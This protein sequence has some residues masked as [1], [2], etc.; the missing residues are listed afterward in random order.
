[1]RRDLSKGD[2]PALILAVL[3][4]GPCH[5]YAI[6]REIERQSGQLFQMREGKLYPLLRV[7]EQ[8]GFIEGQWDTRVSGA[9]R[10]VYALTATG[11]GELA[12]R[13]HAWKNYVDGVSSI[14]GGNKDAQPA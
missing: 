12:K 5:G 3:Q 10:K 14:L 8:D 6:A 7:L 1:M 2:A 4:Q 9:A 11:R 13:K